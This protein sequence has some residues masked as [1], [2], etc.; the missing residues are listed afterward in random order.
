MKAIEAVVFKRL[1]RW[2]KP[3]TS[4]GVSVHSVAG[5]MWTSDRFSSVCEKNAS[6]NGIETFSPGESSGKQ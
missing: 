2:D 5:Q 3:Q 1:Q 6:F 4:S